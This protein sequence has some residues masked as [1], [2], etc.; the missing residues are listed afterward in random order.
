MLDVYGDPNVTG[1]IG[2][3]VQDGKCTWPAVRAMQKL[4][5][6][7]TNDLETFKNSFGKPDAESIETVKK[8]YAQLKLREEFGRFEK[9]MNDGIMES[10][11]NLPEDLQPLS[12]FF[13]GT[14][15]HLMDRK[16]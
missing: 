13:E 5:Q 7:K 2:T 4:Q 12:S 6:N 11:R 14:L 1:K 10:V 15:H 3:D 8:I 16:K 9:Y